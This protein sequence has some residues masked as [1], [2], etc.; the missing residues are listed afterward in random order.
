MVNRTITYN[1]ATLSLLSPASATFTFVGDNSIKIHVPA[2][3]SWGGEKW[4]W[5][6]LDSLS[7]CNEIESVKGRLMVSYA[8]N[9]L[10]SGTHAGAEGARFKFQLEEWERHSWRRD[11][12]LIKDKPATDLIV[13]LRANEDLYRNACSAVL[14]ASKDPYLS[15]T[16]LWVKAVFRF[17]ALWPAARTWLVAKCLWVQVQVMHEHF[18]YRKFHGQVPFITIWALAHPWNFFEKGPPDYIKKLEWDSAAR[19]SSMVQKI[20]LWVGIYALGMQGRYD[21]YT[22]S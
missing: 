18:G 21:E 22:P 5:H 19:V 9:A 8:P 3:S 10:T 20:C 1:T 17:F 12:H 6:R 4:H 13:L 16:P 15:T 14:D 7:R 2:S 11:P